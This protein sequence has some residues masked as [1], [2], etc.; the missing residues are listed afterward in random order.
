[1]AQDV[2]RSEKLQS[3][4]SSGSTGTPITAIC[5]PDAHRKFIAAREVRSFGWAG[6]SVHMPRSTL[7]GRMIIPRGDA[8]PP[9]YR[10][11]WAE[12]QLYLSAYHISPKTIA[13]YVQGF[14]RYQPMLLTGYAHAHFLLARMMLDAGLSLSYQPKAI[15]LSSEQLTAEMRPVISA[16]LRA[17]AYTEYSAVENCI[18]ATECSHGSLH[19]SPDFGVLEIV[20]TNGNPSA[21]GEEGR[22]LCTGLLNDAQPLVRYE[23]GDVAAWSSEKCPCG[24]D[25]FPV[26]QNLVGRIEDVVIG[27]DGREIN[28]FHGIFIDLDHVIEGQIVQQK[29]DLICVNVVASAGF[30]ERDEEVIRRRIAGERLPGMRVDIRKVDHI[31]RTASGKFRAVV[32]LVRFEQA[33]G[34][35]FK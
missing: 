3:Y 2:A 22:V 19:V 23:I 9:Y 25:Q 27:L 31:E 34:A 11:N 7:G 16:A 30:D 15:V 32:S 8:P 13:N 28:R 24:R 21:P 26:L 5:T 1:V 29:R 17:R 12:K 4:H 18:L 14:E 10:Y 20:D 6:A 35:P 33:Q